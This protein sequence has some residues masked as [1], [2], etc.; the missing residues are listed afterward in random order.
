V[1]AEKL[2]DDHFCGVAPKDIPRLAPALIPLIEKPLKRMGS[3]KF[4]SAQDV[5]MKCYRG[6]WQ[7]WILW[8]DE[9]E[10]VVITHLDTYPTGHK[11]ITVF[12]V[13]GKNMMAGFDVGFDTILAF[14]REHGCKEM[15]GFGR[16]AWL[17]LCRQKGL[18]PKTLMTF[19]AEI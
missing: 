5:L 8:G 9:I 17:R 12:L 13:G 6:E 18:S 1:I 16:K 10:T 3:D 14:G 4:Y 2:I 15:I 11:T 7:C 19:F